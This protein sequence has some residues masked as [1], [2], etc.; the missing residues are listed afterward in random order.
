MIKK[1][2]FLLLL[3][4]SLI[5]HDGEDHGTDKKVAASTSYF[6]S[7]AATDKYELLIKYQTI[8]VGKEAGFKLF[9]TDYATNKA[10]DPR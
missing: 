1:I 10:I 2:L 5:A 6:S 4:L 3:P 8:P 7:E 9:I